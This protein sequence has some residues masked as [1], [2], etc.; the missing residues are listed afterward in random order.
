MSAA[1]G[2]KTEDSFKELEDKFKMRCIVRYQDKVTVRTSEV[3]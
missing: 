2:S 1:V 3:E